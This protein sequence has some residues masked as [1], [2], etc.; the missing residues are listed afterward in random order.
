MQ[1][2][3]H[4]SFDAAT[5]SIAIDVETVNAVKTLAKDGSEDEAADETV[6][7]KGSST[8]DGLG[9]GVGC[10]PPPHQHHSTKFYQN[11]RQIKINLNLNNLIMF[12]SISTGAAQR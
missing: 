12:Y 7:G 10:S 5:F 4:S 1:S 2:V 6:V 3:S 9:G 11:Y 8:S